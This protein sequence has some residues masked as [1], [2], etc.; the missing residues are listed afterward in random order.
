MHTHSVYLIQHNGSLVPRPS[1]PPVFDHFQYQIWR[2]RT[3]RSCAMCQVSSRW[4]HGGAVPDKK[5]LKALSCNVHP[6]A[7]GWNVCKAA[8][9]QLF[10]QDTGD[11]STQYL[12]YYSQALPPV[13]LPSVYLALRDAIARHEISQAFLL[14][15]W[16]WKQSKTGG[17]GT[18]LK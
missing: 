14:T 8:S 13:W 1:L 10:V 18:R 4:T 6:R 9:I 17:L 3:G 12:N 16:Y 7:G 11:W 15:I 2:G 5:Y